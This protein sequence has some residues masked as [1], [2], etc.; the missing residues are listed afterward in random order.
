MIFI[1]KVMKNVCSY[2]KTVE[3]RCYFRLST[4]EYDATMC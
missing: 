2:K 4:V 1:A 3:S